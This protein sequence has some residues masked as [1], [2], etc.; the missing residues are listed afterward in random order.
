MPSATA[1]DEHLLASCHNT[2]ANKYN[3]LHNATSLQSCEA[4]CSA[5]DACLQI[6]FQHV[7]PKWCALYNV[8]TAPGR[9][10]PGTKY[11]C[12]CKGD[13]PS[14]PGPGPGPGPKPPKPSPV[15]P[16]N[17][18]LDFNN[19]YYFGWAMYWMM[20]LESNRPPYETVGHAQSAAN[21]FLGIHLHDTQYYLRMG[22]WV[23]PDLHPRYAHG[24][25][26]MWQRAA[27]S[28]QY[29]N[30][31]KGAYWPARSAKGL[32]PDNMGSSWIASS[33]CDQLHE[34]VED[35]WTIYTRSGVAPQTHSSRLR[36]T[37]SI[38]FCDQPTEISPAQT[39]NR[40][41]GVA[42]DSMRS[43]TFQ[44]ATALG[45]HEDAAAWP[46]LLAMRHLFLHCGALS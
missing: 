32:M 11:D 17:R 23:V 31:S 10:A 26:L 8:S 1:F 42:R 24:N 15:P 41:G 35:S 4:A 33:T 43:D 39:R 9:A 18:T 5:D 29:S 40:A 2:N 38:L 44:M 19:A 3:F 36:M 45:K 21:N 37:C 14:T 6:E 46:Q 30:I 7:S 12:A 13:C 16:M 34:I 25:V 20:L 27:H 28:P 22:S